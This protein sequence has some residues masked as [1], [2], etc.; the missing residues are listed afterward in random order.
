MA[1][2]R[3]ESRYFFFQKWGEPDSPWW[4]GLL[5][6]GFVVCALLGWPKTI[7]TDEHGI[8]CYWW[9]RRKAAIPWKEVEYAETGSM[10]A[11]EVA[12]ANARI[13]FEGY[14]AGRKRFCA[15]LKKRSCVKKIV[16]PSEF[17]GLHLN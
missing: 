11:I 1:G 10:G 17:T 15:E 3:R 2:Y 14:N 5:L 8:E 4:A 16:I 9:W 13:V 6:A 12:G 7:M